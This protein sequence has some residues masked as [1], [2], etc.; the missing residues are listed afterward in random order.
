MTADTPEKLLVSVARILNNLG[1]NYFVTGGF[2]VSVWGRPRATFDID[3][4]IQILESQ[5]ADLAQA[6]KLLV[7]GGYLDED[8]ARAAARKS[9]GGFNFIDSSTGLKVDFFVKKP[10][11]FLFSQFKRRK[12]K[13]VGGEKIPFISPEDLI[14]N[15]LIWSKEG[16]SALQ[17]E[18]VKSIL[19][20]SGENL[21]KDYINKWSR[22][23]D[24][25]NLLDDLQ[26]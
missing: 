3:I 25:N 2:A 4:V 17:I 13:I 10:D 5:V 20:I 11:D 22:Q 12:I 18:D 21:D 23:L 6:L 16:G 8:T 15:K 9:S 7:K 24:V 1:I 26:K 19:K 14:L